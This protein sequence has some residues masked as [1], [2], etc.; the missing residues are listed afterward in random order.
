MNP[1]PEAKEWAVGAKTL[2]RGFLYASIVILL[3]L[4]APGTD[5]VFVYQ[6][7]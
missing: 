7:F 2:L 1:E 3:V 6:A 5:H 4:L